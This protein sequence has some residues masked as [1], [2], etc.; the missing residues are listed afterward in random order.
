MTTTA[1]RTASALW[2]RDRRTTTAGLL[3]MVTMAAFE[4]MSV[5]TAMPT[6]V[7]ELR[8]EALY[9]WPFTAFL[10]ASVVGTVLSGRLSDTRGPRL[11]ILGGPAVFG[12]GLVV[13]GAAPTMAVLLAGRVLQGLGAGMM[14]V[15]V[16]VLI[17][18]AYPERDRPAAFGA[19][20]AAWVVPA[21]VGPTIAGLVTEHASWRWV[22]LGLAPFVLLG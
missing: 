2:A 19:V 20:S 6:M 16:Y 9:S 18:L 1:P 21:L 10:A 13:A 15:A 4:A 22:F 7:A 17:A 3:L 12:A 8:G 5:G 11:P 14:I